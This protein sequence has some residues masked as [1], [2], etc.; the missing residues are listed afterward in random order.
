[1]LVLFCLLRGQFRVLVMLTNK[2]SD[3][4][5]WQWTMLEMIIILPSSCYIFIKPTAH[6]LAIAVPC[7]YAGSQYFP[8]PCCFSVF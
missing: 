2:L 4:Q 5:K 3:I 7:I 8:P 1:M 6:C